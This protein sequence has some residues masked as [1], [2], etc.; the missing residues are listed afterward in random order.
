METR[1]ED[2]F[3][4]MLV[5]VARLLGEPAIAPVFWCVDLNALLVGE[6]R[7]RLTPA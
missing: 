3:F 6:K 1:G 7:G 5:C 2:G 4:E